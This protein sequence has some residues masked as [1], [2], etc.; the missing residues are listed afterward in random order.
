MAYYK[1]DEASLT[2]VA[3]A[4]RERAGTTEPMQFPDG[5][6]GAVNGIP[7]GVPENDVI[8]LIEKTGLHFDIP[9]GCTK[10]GNSLFRASSIKTVTIP[11]TVTLIDSMAF[12]QSGLNGLVELPSNLQTIAGT[13]FQQCYGLVITRMPASVQK[14]EGSA[15]YACTAIT[16]LTFDGTPTSIAADAFSKCNNLAVINVPWEEGAVA[17]A[18]WGAPIATINYNY[19]GG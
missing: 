1:V 14:I 13:A 9:Y 6:V 17:D 10:I 11:D 4:I 8:G 12:F 15:F 5:F 16:S 2:A 7:S 18:P 19:S 3:D